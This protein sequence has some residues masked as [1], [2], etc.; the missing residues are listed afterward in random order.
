MAQFQKLASI[1]ENDLILSLFFS[2]GFNL[3]DEN[4]SAEMTE[5]VLSM[6]YQYLV[7]NQNLQL[8]RTFQVYL[9][10][11]SVNHMNARKIQAVRRSYPRR[12][13]LKNAVG[14]G[15][16][17][18]K[19]KTAVGSGN[20][21][22]E[23]HR[24]AI[25]VSI[26]LNEFFENKCLLLCTIL[27]LLQHSYF[28]SNKKDRRF[29]SASQINS[30]CDTKALRAS[31]ILE[32]QLN[33]LFSVTNLKRTGPYQ[34][35]G[36]LK[37]LSKFYKI[38]FFIFDG[39]T[40]S[41]RL[42]TSYPSSFNPSLKP[43]FLYKSF[44]N[45][46][47]LLFIKN[48]NSYFRSNLYVCLGCKRSFKTKL[49]MHMCKVVK[50]CFACRR[51][52]QK[53]DTY[54][55]EKLKLLF[56][57]RYLT[58]EASKQCEICHCTVYSM[59]CAKRHKRYCNGK[60]NFGFKCNDCNHFFYATSGKN[61]L[62]LK[63]EHYCS[64]SRRCKVC[65]EPKDIDH[66]C[67][68]RPEN[69]P[70]SHCRLAFFSIVAE[71]KSLDN[72]FSFIPL[73]AVILREEAE[74]GNFTKYNISNSDLFDDSTK[75]KFYQFD[76]FS[77]FHIKNFSFSNAN[78]MKVKV[79]ED[80]RT[81]KEKIMTKDNPDCSE[82]LLAFFLS[83]QYK[84]TTYLCDDSKSF[85]L[86]GLL[87]LFIKFGICP[88]IVKKGN[89]IILLEIQ[90]IGIR[91]LSSSS[92]VSGD[93]YN[94]AKQF[95]V[96][97][98]EIYFPTKLI[99]FRNFQY[100]GQIPDEV[101]FIST[102]DTNEEIIKKRAFVRSKSSQKW[103]FSKEIL[104]QTDEKV[105]LL[106][107]SLLLL[108][109]ESFE[110]QQKLKQ[111][112]G[113]HNE[114]NFLNPFNFPIC[115]ISGFVYRLFKCLYMNELNLFS[116]NNEYGSKFSRQVSKVEFEYACYMDYKYPK[117]EFQ[118]AFNNKNG[119]RYF[120]ETTPDL[121]SAITKEAVYLH[122]CYYHAHYENCQINKNVSGKTI[123]PFGYTFEAIN[124]KFIEKRANLLK[125]HPTEVE[126]VVIEW[127]CN[128]QKKRLE[129]SSIKDYFDNYFIYHPMIRLKP[130]DS[131]RG[132]F[133]DVYGLRWDQKKC[134][135]E[136][137]FCADINGLYSFCTINFPFMKGKYDILMGKSLG[138]ISLSNGKFM[139][140]NQPMMGSI[141]L[142][143]LP[144]K[145]LLYP[146]L[147]YKKKNGSIVNTLC[148]ACAEFMSK[149][150]THS[151]QER[152]IVGVYMLSE[153][154]Y[155]LKIG[156]TIMYIYEVHCY[157]EFDFLLQDFVKKLNYLKTKYT[158][159]FRGYAKKSEKEKY[160]ETLNA[161]MKLLQPDF[162]LSV[163]D[164]QS[165]ERK[166][167]FY[168]LLANSFF[169]KFIQRDDRSNIVFVKSQTDVEKIYNKPET[170]EDISCFG[171]KICMLYLKKNP[172]HIL[173][174]LRQNVYIGS[175]ITAY[176]RQ[177]IHEH[178]LTLAS[179]PN[180]HL[181]HVDCDCLFFSLPKNLQ[182]PLQ[183]SHAVG[184]FKLEFQNVLSYYSFGPKQYCVSVVQED[185]KIQSTCKFSGLS[186][187]TVVNESKVNQE[188]IA[189]YLDNFVEGI[190]SQMVLTQAR[191]KNN[192][193]NF[194]SIDFMQQYTFTNKLSQRRVIDSTNPRLLT[195]PY[196]FNDD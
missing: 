196:G 134:P 55:H 131:V 160:C 119:Q 103:N 138:N 46:N 187:N 107:H 183:F 101:H 106:A 40:N 108:L 132:A 39:I 38:Q 9:K 129:D 105:L 188:T 190:N 24:W 182:C 2:G 54:M 43:I 75:S 155:A 50:A 44:S 150:C 34:L 41:S 91:F 68:L 67:R 181:Y 111:S 114:C 37:L 36:T 47:H 165:N 83:E 71:E 122:G 93:T 161:K 4:A 125:N 61:T 86:M 1:H 179:I 144:P 12:V 30:S 33:N 173:P 95:G 73:F 175:Q 76:Y 171:D 79:T 6:L 87:D 130:R 184:D 28:E 52:F 78:C 148:T 100:C 109:S 65:H 88:H 84:N 89:Q 70:Q 195:F 178:L 14:S 137:F 121:Y 64:Q 74:R 3:Q 23:N 151:D 72:D 176:A 166:R 90:E 185:T 31:Q 20:S 191:H 153:I 77:K 162:K 25:D 53:G 66:L 29:I 157:L 56:C 80:F 81:N 5:R 168:K 156:Y 145:N 142:M 123:H 189:L 192:F 7:S 186:L 169:G 21:R 147:L 16:R 143:I 97:F 154:E 17:R 82:K 120:K 58:Q 92:Y 96:D 177:V 136:E 49:N 110:V 10:V 174:N 18:V 146:F 8:N 167:T 164:C 152:A 124:K 45:P 22:P 32:K 85:I 99:F 117:K 112:L 94:L 26:K 104:M 139:Y 62:Q 27:G 170:I 116:V 158:D 42:F 135:D 163:A 60:G 193:S 180:C 51:F 19:F 113:M 128:F 98:Q 194:K 133:I 102:W 127:E 59:H 15:N 63:E 69:Y 141:L 159:C 126:K 35:N 172:L 118:T 57:D 48:L 149:N 13:K 115:S 140:L 11:L